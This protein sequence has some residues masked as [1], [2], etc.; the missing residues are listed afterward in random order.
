M[1][2][3]I[4]ILVLIVLLFS[5]SNISGLATPG[6]EKFL[7]TWD[8]VPGNDSNR[9]VEILEKN[10]INDSI[11]KEKI[12][13]IDKKNIVL[14]TENDKNISLKLNDEETTVSLMID[15]NK[16]ADFD[17]KSETGQLKVYEKAP[18]ISWYIFILGLIAGLA[19]AGLMLLARDKWR[20]RPEPMIRPEPGTRV[21]KKTPIQ[22]KG[23]ANLVTCSITDK[24]NRDNNEDACETFAIEF[25]TG[26]LH[27]LAVADG[28]GGHKA[29]EV[30]SKLAI[31]E[32]INDIRETISK[33]SYEKISRKDMRELLANAYRKANNE[34][35]SKSTTVPELHKMGSTLVAALV[36][37]EGE[38]IVANIGDSRAYQ[39]GDGMRRITKDQSYVQELIDRDLITPEEAAVHPQKNV[40]NKIIGMKSVEPDLFEIGLG[41]DTLVLCS[42][43]ITDA[44]NDEEIRH[45]VINSEIN[46]VCK[47]L[48][49]A[50]KPKCRDNITVVAGRLK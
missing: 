22:P 2:K 34:V 11:K 10:Y 49:E 8:Q 13:K 7:F 48:I 18:Q 19:I 23:K 36:N 38:G 28:L 35:Y 21:T 44:M 1:R 3:A 24:G 25:S 50:A 9:L 40:V 27:V 29:G 17:V 45:I 41:G 12:L 4:A 42:D 37:D 20:K 46:Q 16:I 43:G 26:K 39:V 31:N 14:F 33:R 15:N 47:N 5:I 30:A 6:N 32:L